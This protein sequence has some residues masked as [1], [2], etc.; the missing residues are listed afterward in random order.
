MNFL[1]VNDDGIESEGLH[2]LANA[3]ATVGNVYVAAPDTQQSGKSLSI[4]LMDS[5]RVNEYHV[6]NAVKAW[7]VN[8]TPADCTKVGIQKCAEEGAKIDVVFSGINRGS[9]LGCDTL[10]SG[11]VG[12]AMEAALHDLHAVAV[13]VNHHD[14]KY[15]AAACSL[16]LQVIDYVVN[17]PV[18]IVV[19]INT[20]NLPPE[21]ILGIKYATLGQS[22]YVDEFVHKEDDIYVLEG[23]IPDYSHV[24]DFI[25]VGANYKGYATVTPMMFDLTA[26]DFIER[27]GEWDL[28]L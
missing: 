2:A 28:K 27:V 24:P 20:P 19:N 9:N 13:S 16:A 12:A 5:I 25:D 3:L 26:Y 10:Y 6:P 1:L 21:E 14:A 8:G 22:N 15:F 17:L 23:Y 11:T 7:R 4:S 18:N